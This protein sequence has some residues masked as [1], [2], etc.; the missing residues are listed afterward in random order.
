MKK[1]IMLIAL[2][3]MVV[4]TTLTVKAQGNGEKVGQGY[5]IEGIYYEVYVSDDI[6]GE[7]VAI[8]G[9]GV[10]VV[11]EVVYSGLVTPEKTITW[12]EMIGGTYYEGILTLKNF[13]AS[14]TKT[15]ATYA[16]TIYK[17]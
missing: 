16:G 13:S 14:K 17:E 11:R 15:V 3:I 4:N 8:C 10:S 7:N 1:T 5:T 6:D 9:T 12:R 2:A